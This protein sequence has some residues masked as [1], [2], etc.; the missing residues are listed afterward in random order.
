MATERKRDRDASIVRACEICGS[1]FHPRRSA[2]PTVGGRF[3][4]SGC[5]NT[6]PRQTIVTAFWQRFRV[7]ATSGCWEWVGTRGAHGYGLVALDGRRFL[8]HRVSYRLHFGD[9]PSGAHVCHRCDNPACVNPDHLFLGDMRSNHADKVSKGRQAR[10]DGH[11]NA[12]LS[13][14]DVVAMRDRFAAHEASQRVLAHEYG[15][16]PSH[17]SNIVNREAWKHV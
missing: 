4:S 8:A 13:T 17:V 11:G 1:S 3:C 10:G 15:V 2:R 5:A 14:A 6:R 16:S 7:D 9:L 12:V